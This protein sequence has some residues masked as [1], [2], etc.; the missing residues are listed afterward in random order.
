MSAVYKFLNAEISISSANTVYSSR[1][2]RV[3]NT[4]N[5]VGVLQIANT[6]ANTANVTLVPYEVITVEKDVADTV[7]GANLRAVPVAYR[8]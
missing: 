7:S 5:A 6:T 3:T 2:I 8:N 4:T 1:V